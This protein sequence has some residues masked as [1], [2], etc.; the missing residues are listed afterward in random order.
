MLYKVSAIDFYQFILTVQSDR[1]MQL[2]QSVRLPYY[3][4]HLLVAAVCNNASR[5]KL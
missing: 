3:Y 5:I 4:I 1:G 2:K